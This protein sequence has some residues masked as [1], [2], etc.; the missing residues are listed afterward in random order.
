MVEAD[1]GVRADAAMVAYMD[2]EGNND[3]LDYAEEN[4]DLTLEE[5]TVRPQFSE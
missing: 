4:I 1:S 3:V 2:M 5:D